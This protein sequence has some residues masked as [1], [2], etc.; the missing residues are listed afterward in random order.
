MLLDLAAPII[1]FY[2]LR[3]AGQ[4][5]FLALTAG[6]IAP[7]LSML[8]K[9]AKDRRVDGLAVAVLAV[10]LLSAGVSLLDGSPRFLAAKDSVLTS[11]WGGWF[12]LSLRAKRPLTF[13]FSRPMLEGRKVFDFR[14]R[15]WVPPSGESWDQMWRRSPQFRRIWVV[16]TVI[17][18][19]ALLLD[20]A[21]RVAMAYSLPID[22]VPAVGGAVWI[23]TLVAL[24]IITNIY[25]LRSGLWTVLLGKSTRINGVPAVARSGGLD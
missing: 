10:L 13:R 4:G 14:G 1:V 2:G 12:F 8:L 22:S 24:Q 3:W 15:R 18:G 19:I 20:A 6:A 11:A 7:A 23:V 17:W 25:F 16:T 5:V 21:V 9:V